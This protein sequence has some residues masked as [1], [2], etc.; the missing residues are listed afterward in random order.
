MS[1]ITGISGGTFSIGNGLFGNLVKLIAILTGMYALYV[2]IVK[3]AFLRIIFFSLS[4]NYCI[5]N[6]NSD[7]CELHALL[8]GANKITTDLVDLL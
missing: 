8:T 3:R 5:D 4:N 1:N 7:V 2:F 6:C